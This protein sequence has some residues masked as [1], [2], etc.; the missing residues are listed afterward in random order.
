MDSTSLETVRLRPGM[1]LLEAEARSNF[2]FALAGLRDNSPVVF[3]RPIKV[4]YDAEVGRVQLPPTL[5]LWV[6]QLGGTV[7]DFTL[8]PQLDG[9][10][11]ESARLLAGQL[12]A[13]VRAAGW[14]P[15]AGHRSKEP[16]FAEL[17]SLFAQQA[18]TGRFNLSWGMWQLGSQ[19]LDINI[20]ELA[21]GGE[22]EDASLP[23]KRFLVNVHV[24][25][26][27][28]FAQWTQRVRER[29]R[30][31]GVSMDTSLPLVDWIGA[32]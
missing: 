13:V 10:P 20:K 9:V 14:Q 29:R 30:L 11:L 7:V 8:A 32:R 2:R 31:N 22:G 17:Q 16:S 27:E 23:A 24:A 5:M 26:D 15:R 25:D 4:V 28:V 21:S 12:G 1:S 18:A 6:N 19:R 3:E